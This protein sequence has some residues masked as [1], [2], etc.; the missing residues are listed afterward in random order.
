[1]R[2]SVNSSEKLQGSR[3]PAFADE[4]S[5]LVGSLILELV[6]FLALEVLNRRTKKPVQ[7][8]CIMR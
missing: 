7:S 6:D 5:S 8:P 2:L 1:M 4:R 3:R